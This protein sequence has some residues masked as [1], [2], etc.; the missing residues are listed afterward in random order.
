MPLDYTL[1]DAPYPYNLITDI[2]RAPVVELMD[3][4]HEAGLEKALGRLDSR[5][6]RCIH[7]MYKDGLSLEEMAGLLNLSRERVRQITKKSLHKLRHPYYQQFIKLGVIGVAE[8]LELDHRKKT[9]DQRT[10]ALEEREQ[11]LKKAFEA[12]NLVAKPYGYE[13]PDDSGEDSPQDHLDKMPI[14]EL[15]LTVRSYNCLKRINVDTFKDLRELASK[16]NM[17]RIRNLGVQSLN[18]ILDKLLYFGYDYF[19]IN[20][21]SK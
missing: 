2:F 17:L 8:K 11:T 10:R 13:P 6:R 20:N 15:D 21:A 9:L 16:G 5:E 1:N 12:I 18:E 4:D 19:D 7:M 14:E 3:E